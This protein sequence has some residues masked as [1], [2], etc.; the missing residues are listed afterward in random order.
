MHHE[1][2]RSKLPGG[3]GNGNLAVVTQ[4]CK[5]RIQETEEGELPWVCKSN[6]NLGYRVNS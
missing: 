5:L 4:S 3:K 6:S 1:N 2:V